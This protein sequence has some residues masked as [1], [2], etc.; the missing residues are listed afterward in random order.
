MPTTRIIAY[1]M[2][3][4]EWMAAEAIEVSQRT[5]SFVIGQIDESALESLREQGVVIDVLPAA[6]PPQT[7]AA[8][9]SAMAQQ[10]KVPGWIPDQEVQ[11]PQAAQDVATQWLVSTDGPLDEER[12][13]QITGTGAVL[14]EYV[15]VFS[16]I[17]SATAEQATELINLGFVGEVIRYGMGVGGPVALTKL[18]EP[19]MGFGGPGGPEPTR[20]WDLWLADTSAREVVEN[21]LRENG[22]E[23]VGA[24]GRKIRFR[25]ADSSALVAQIGM[26]PGV[27]SMMEYV[28]PQLF[29]DAARTIIGVTSGNPGQD[30]E[31]DGTGQI[32]GVADTGLDQD[33]EDFA[34][35]LVDVVALGRPGD[36]SDPHGHGTHVSGS[37]L[38]DGKASGGDLRGVAPA[39]KLYFQSVLDANG[40]LGGLPVALEDLFEPAYQAGARIHNNSWGAATSS[41]YTVNSIEVDDYVAKR[42][43][44]LVVIA[45]GNSG[46]AA[47]PLNSTKGYVDWLSIGSPASCKNAL[48]V[49]AARTS[50]TTGGIAERSYGNVWATNF[51][52][53]PIA[54]EKV[55]GNP[56]AMAAFSSRGPCD[57][58]RIK[59]DLV[60]PGTDILS[61]RSKDAPDQ[62]FW[63]LH[64]NASYAYMGGT[65]MA[66][67]I[68]AGC[69]TLVRQY[70]VDER[71]IEP[72]AALLKA[73]LINGTRWLSADD[74]VAGH[75]VKPNYHQGFGAVYL[76]TTIPSKS[77][78]V[79]DLE[80]LDTWQ[81]P[82]L[83]LAETGKRLVF[84]IQVEAGEPLRICMAYTDLPGRALQNDLSLIIEDPNQKKYLGNADL[85]G[86]ITSSDVENNVEAIEVPEPVAGQWR[87]QVFAR[88]L[89]RGPQDFALVATGKFPGE[90]RRALQ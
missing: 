14:E 15:P 40:G 32:V 58:R 5:D 45:A 75:A 73:T 19:A 10:T 46:T 70:Y 68:V 77:N 61:T 87:I 62:S 83:Q 27:L 51:P 39:A 65:S 80:F 6:R 23:P 82:N 78:P 44:M 25:L 2:H 86:A 3:E 28:P 63:G 37:V 90:L 84:T 66:C 22:I 24:S 13:R 38:A 47:N 55:S 59:P 69:A 36:P 48:T 89:L 49:G 60:A 53:P 26:L 11:I 54:D 29:N 31:Y 81:T 34:G 64:D 9:R 67:P 74:S 41:A 30:V 20:T 72:S 1:P 7:A 42:R 12:R 56:E 43:D 21:W 35:R 85:P 50:R 57:D 18:P 16:Y 4:H 33:H 52:D 79:F 76:P 8:V 88:N 71:R 17:V